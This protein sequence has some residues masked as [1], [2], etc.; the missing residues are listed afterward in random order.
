MYTTRQVADSLGIT[1][2]ALRYYERVGLLGPIQ[3]DKNGIREYSDEDVDHAKIIHIL[4][5]MNMP[6]QVILD[7]MADVDGDAPTVDSLQRFRGQLDIL[8]NRLEGQIVAIKNEET[9]LRRKMKRVDADIIEAQQRTKKTV[10]P[11]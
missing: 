7:T 2:N 3:R 4:R 6:I 8:M 5:T 1:P 11:K 9:V 10:S